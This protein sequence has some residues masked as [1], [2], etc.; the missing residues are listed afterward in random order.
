ML[1]F[2]CCYAN[3]LM[4]SKG[5][6]I[7]RILIFEAKFVRKKCVLYM[8]KYSILTSYILKSSNT[9]HLLKTFVVFTPI[10]RSSKSMQGICHS[11]F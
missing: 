8:G 5:S 10:I 2:L 9:N 4:K 11:T 7:M 6:C 3:Y 1:Y